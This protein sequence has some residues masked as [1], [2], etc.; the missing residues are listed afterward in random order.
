MYVNFATDER[1]NKLALTR[2]SDSDVDPK[3]T[4]IN[5]KLKAMKL[6]DVDVSGLFSF[7]FFPTSSSIS[8]ADTSLP[9]SQISQ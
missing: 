8:G 2:L 9:I 6:S 5:P 3:Q 7:S 4:P 1:E